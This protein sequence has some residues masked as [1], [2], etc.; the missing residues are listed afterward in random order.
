MP[1]WTLSYKFTDREFLD[2][3]E[4]FLLHTPE[5]KKSLVSLRLLVPAI[6]AITA[7]VFFLRDKNLVAL[8]IQA[9]LYCIVSVVWWFCCHRL[10]LFFLKRRLKNP[11]SIEKS[12]FSPR[13]T[14]VVD[15]EKCII[16]DSGEAE[17]VRL[18]FDKVTS[19]YETLTA[20]CFYFGA[21]KA[22]VLP[23]TAFKTTE[24][25]YSFQ[26]LVRCTFG[27]RNP[28]TKK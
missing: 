8:A 16:I 25:F 27:E 19:Y 5:G 2:F 12:M 23:Y 7:V 9:F 21:A 26:H 18:H 17:E 1:V 15:F 24:D 6:F 22:I 11:K 13:G 14:L 28:S 3:N 4:H 10:I 20:F